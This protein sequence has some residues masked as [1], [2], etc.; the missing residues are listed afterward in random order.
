MATGILA[1]KKVLFYR[2][3]PDLLEQLKQY[4]ALTVHGT[5][6]RATKLRK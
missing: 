4:L 1:V 2:D 6:Q 5:R 3:I